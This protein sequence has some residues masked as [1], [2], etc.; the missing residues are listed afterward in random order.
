MRKTQTK[1]YDRTLLVAEL[2]IFK[3]TKARKKKVNQN[4]ES[5]MIDVLGTV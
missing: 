4:I 5:L 1:F 2:F 3:F